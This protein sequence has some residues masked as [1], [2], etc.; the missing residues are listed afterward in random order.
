[1]R[2]WKVHNRRFKEFRVLIVMA[3]EKFPTFAYGIRLYFLFLHF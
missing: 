1:M 3:H 2:F